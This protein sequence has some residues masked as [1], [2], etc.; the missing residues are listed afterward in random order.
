MSRRKLGA[1]IFGAAT[2]IVIAFSAYKALMGQEIGFN[3]IAAIGILL[4]IFLSAITWGDR[5]EKEGIYQDEELGQ[6][7]TEKSSKISYYILIFCILLAVACDKMIH[8]TV[9][10]F[11]LLVLALAMIILPLVEFFM[12]RKYRT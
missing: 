7:I 9:N 2:L 4:M 11:L 5:E 10:I 12:V 3:E 6:E 1:L 8:G